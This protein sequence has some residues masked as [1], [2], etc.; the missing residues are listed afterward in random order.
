MNLREHLP[1][2]I[3]LKMAAGICPVKVEAQDDGCYTCTFQ[4]EVP[5]LHRLEITCLGQPVGGCP[6]SVK[7]SRHKI[8][9]QSLYCD[10]SESQ[11][12]AD[13]DR[14]RSDT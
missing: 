2:E 14:T 3:E 9:M 12:G 4:P 11:P 1:L 8:P 10:I 7:A 6:F 13:C 5:G